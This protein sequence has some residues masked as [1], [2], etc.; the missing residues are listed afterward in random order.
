MKLRDFQIEDGATIAKV[1]SALVAHEPRVGKTGI[2]IHAANLLRAKI[3]VV[4]CP[5]GVKDNWRKA[6][7]VFRVGQ[8]IAII[9]SYNKANEVLKVLR[10]SRMRICVLVV[11]E[12]QYCK[13]RSANRTRVIYGPM[14]DGLGGLA[15][16][17]DHVY[18]LTGTPMPNNPTELW[19]MLRA[20]APHL[21]DN[22]RG[23]PMSWSSFRDRYC[24]QI[25]TPYGVKIIGGK[26]YKE[27]KDKLKTF[28]LRRTRAS[29]FGRDLLPPTTVY[30]RAEAS[31]KS[32]LAALSNSAAG[33]LVKQALGSA[34]PL[35]MLAKAEKQAASLRKLF[36]IAKV[37]GILRLVAEELDIE[38]REK[39]VLFAYHHAVIDALR[40]GLKQYGA[41]AFDGRTSPDRKV[42]I[43]KK[44]LSDSTCRVMIGQISAAGVGLDFSAANNVLFA[45]QDWVGDN[46]EQARSRIFNMAS[47]DPKFTRFAVLLGS[48]DE[49][50]A[51][52]CA[53]KMSDFKKIFA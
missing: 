37:P 24:K 33:L 2:T 15:E 53:R 13:E 34:N 17:A 29:V 23:K 45:E 44:F 14:C 38:P 50:I 47:L 16:F 27:L 12:S 25:Q 30:V 51:M 35:K 41:V 5:A 28:V 43:N 20:L 11:D 31:H 26:N 21:I 8:W 4:V 3:F 32:E 42:A 1:R 39:I 46:N 7:E 9:V 52:A 40:I 22:G 18:C 48:M 10:N 6:I 49:Q 36:G 19:P